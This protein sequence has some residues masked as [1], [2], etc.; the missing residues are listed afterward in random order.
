LIKQCLIKKC[1]I[2]QVLTNTVSP[3]TVRS[4]LSSYRHALP[5]TSCLQGMSG[6]R[7]G[8]A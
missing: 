5:D 7:L 8:Q 6:Q 2:K 3:N 1:L 4:G